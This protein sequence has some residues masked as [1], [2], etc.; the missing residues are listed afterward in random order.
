MS[1]PDFAIEA[2]S[3]TLLS[4]G[5]K[6]GLLDGTRFVIPIYQRPY[7]WGHAEVTRLFKTM[8]AAYQNGGEP[9][10]LGT[11]QLMPH[12]D[13]PAPAKH[14]DIIDGQQRLTTL[15]LFFQVLELCFPIVAVPAALRGG[16]WLRTTVNNGEQQRWFAEAL[17][18]SELPAEA[19]QHP[20]PYVANAAHIRAALLA[21]EEAEEEGRPPFRVGPAFLE[22]VLH[23]LHVVVIETRA[24]LAKTLDIFNTINTA[25]LDLNGGDV[26]KIQ[27][28]DYLA[29]RPN[30]TD[31]EASDRIFRQIDELYGRI[32]ANKDEDGSPIT[33][34]GEV[35]EVYKYILI[36]EAEANRALHG[37]AT[38]TFFEQLFAYLLLNEKR[39]EFGKLKDA[40][41]HNPL[42]QL[43]HILDARLAWQ[44]YFQ[45]SYHLWYTLQWWTRYGEFWLLDV[46]Y[47]YQ[48]GRRP[49][50]HPA[51]LREWK[52]LLVRY[53]LI[54]S[55]RY[56]R[57]V[58]AARNFTFDVIRHLL[59][60]DATPASVNALLRER[61]AAEGPEWLRD[62]LV[63]ETIFDNASR[64]QL[65]MRV[66]AL[67]EHPDWDEPGL[68]A[69]YFEQEYDVEHIHP[70]NPDQPDAADEDWDAD[71]HKLGNLVLL[72]RSL[73]RSGAVRN[74]DFHFK[75]TN[76]Y[77]DSEVNSVARL[78]Q[79]TAEPTDATPRTWTPA[80]AQAR[81]A[82]EVERLVRFLFA[83]SVPPATLDELWP[84]PA[85]LAV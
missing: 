24:G 69:K 84:T 66:S 44:A 14:F 1:Y 72:E 70:C 73:N 57:K 47:L 29:R 51:Q 30:V 21:A 80:K 75:C 12:P 85:A 50:Y 9:S 4:S 43:N 23:G 41:N 59:A 78:L 52:T 11:A 26:F 19:A 25:G 45:G 64:C 7:S 13:Q 83:G 42:Q 74:Y 55:F 60:P 48:F 65:L 56:F 16:Q 10:F 17:A 76:G 2:R 32:N 68:R 79:E 71:Q 62:Q 67:L 40:L 5:Q 82:R 27:L 81:T 37:L 15:A 46:V 53:Y 36:E 39:P 61:I 49:D 22:Y 33:S 31:A 35:L 54:Q 18:L 6:P 3:C 38:D 20:N 34:I 63:R 58:Y 8:V 77:V 28:Y